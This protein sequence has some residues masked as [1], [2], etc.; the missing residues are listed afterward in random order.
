MSRSGPSQNDGIS[1]SLSPSEKHWIST[2]AIFTFLGAVALVFWNHVSGSGV[3]IGESDRLNSYLDMRLVEYDA[4][5]EY[6]RIPAWDPSMFGGFSMAALH[7]MNPGKDPVPYLLQFFPRRDVF[8][9]LGYLSVT[10]VFAACVTAFLYIRDVTRDVLPAAV[11]ALAYGLS[12]FSLHRAAQVDNAHLTVVLIPLALLAIRRVRP[13]KLMRPFIGLTV[14]MGAL[15]YWGFLQEVSYAFIFFGAYALYRG[16]VLAPRGARYGLAP[17]LVLAS[18]AFLA[19]LFAAPRLITLHNDISLWGRASSLANDSYSQFL[20]LFHNSYAQI[21]RFFHEGIYG[22][23]FE[24]GMLLGNGMNYSEGLQLVSS[25][26]LS[27][28]V[29]FGIARPANRPQAIAAVVFFALLAAMLPTYRPFYDLVNDALPISIT[30]FKILT[31]G[32][33]CAA[34]LY[35]VLK[36]KPLRT[37][38]PARPLDTTFYLF[39]L[40][41][42]LFAILVPEANYVVYALYFFIDFTHTRLSILAILPLCT[43]L[44]IYLAELNS[45]PA[46]KWPAH[47]AQRYIMPVMVACL[48]GAISYL[49]QSPF[50]EKWIPRDAFRLF[51]LDSSTLMPAVAIS[52]AITAVLLVGLMIAIVF[53]K[54]SRPELGRLVSL[55]IAAFI[56]VE[57]VGY[58]HLKIDGPQT[59]SYPVPFRMFNYLNVSPAVL[60]PPAESKVRLLDK[61]LETDR[62][63]SVVLSEMAGY[64]GIKIS[65]V[66]EFW[67]LRTIGGYSTVVPRPL[68]ALPWPNGVQTLRAIDFTSM[69]NLDASIFPL[70][71]FLNVKYLI[72]LT[73]DVYFNVASG[74]QPDAPREVSFGGKSYPLQTIDVGGTGFH[75]LE[76]PVPPLPRQFLV[77]RIV[78]AAHPPRLARPLQAPASKRAGIRVFED[79]VDD[80][81]RTSFVEGRFIGAT[82]KFDASGPLSVTYRGD[83]I[84]I[85]VAPSAQERFVVLDEAYHP[86][87]RV[88]AG[89]AT[90]KTIPT[91][92]VMTGVLIPPGLDRVELRFMPF[93]SGPRAAIIMAAALFGFILFGF[94]L[95]RAETSQTPPP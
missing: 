59:W 7:W 70:L 89:D 91:N 60:R 50:L 67:G 57:V 10:L 16:G 34:I 48:A 92:L 29:C 23:Y 6:G 39:A 36:H 94:L 84:D 81:T 65:H 12:V 22:R 66:A 8:Q 28:F 27:L 33:L 15:A 52:V 62:Y 32:I 38:T 63:R 76:N 46:Y 79:Q 2:I 3:F 4:L 42:I 68:A 47:S 61:K 69:R 35:L 18:A 51:V 55:A 17:V 93:S 24:E 90:G 82:K 75:I 85:R 19:L 21:L 37:A 1:N 41:A 88:Y 74:N 87:W 5:R 53:L 64:P 72:V 54:S 9:V 49:V 11:G 83:V 25:A 45:N 73:P 13:N 80:L 40:S 26:A 77:E 20:Q 56:A 58:A 86:A 44:A 43:L 31:Y 95:R 78:G 30:L 71:A 14:I